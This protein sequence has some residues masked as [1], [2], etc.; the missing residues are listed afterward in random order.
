MTVNEFV[1]SMEGYY[2]KFDDATRPMKVILITEY[3]KKYNN[4]ELDK[5]FDRLVKRYSGQF[6]F[7][8][9]ISIIEDTVEEINKEYEGKV[10]GERKMIGYRGPDYPVSLRI[11]QEPKPSKKEL[12]PIGNKLKEFAERLQSGKGPK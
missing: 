11:E 2:G 7:T 10:G 6:R 5:I 1:D 12:E 8:P 4:R 9:D 3:L